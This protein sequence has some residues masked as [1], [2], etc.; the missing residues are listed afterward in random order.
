MEI[1]KSESF[2]RSECTNEDCWVIHLRPEELLH[3]IETDRVVKNSFK[4]WIDKQP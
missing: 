3:L 4:E 2:D 1:Y